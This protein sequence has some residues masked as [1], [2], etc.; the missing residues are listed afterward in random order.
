[1]N[2]YRDHKE[3]KWPQLD[4]MKSHIEQIAVPSEIEERIRSGIRIGRQRRRSRWMAKMASYTAVLLFLVSVASVRFSPVVAAYVGDIPGLRSLVELINY[5]K[6]LQLA[7]ENDFMQQVGRFEEHDG[8]K[9]TIDGILADE[10]RVV[11]FYTLKNMNGQRGI[12]NLQDVKLI[13][14]QNTS[15]LYGASDFKEDWIS[16]QGTIDLNFKEGTAV[17]DVLSLQMKVG[18]D[19]DTASKR[20]AWSFDIPVDKTKFE[21]RRETYALNKTVTVEGQRITFGQMTVYPTRIGIEVVYDPNNTKKLFY[22]DNLRIED[23]HGETFGTISNGISGSIVSENRQLLYIQ[24]NYF[25][26]PSKLYLRASS[27]RALDKAKLEVKVDLANKKLLA[28]PDD[29]L[30][31][32]DIGTSAENGQRILVFGL[33]R[34]DPMDN[35]NR[36]FSIFDSTYADASGHRFESNR[37]GST[38]DEYQYFIKNTSYT[39]PLTLSITDYPSRIY[40]DINVRVK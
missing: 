20:K 10:S 24:S 26:K 14:K 40:G 5:D 9:L 13:N 34:E 33:K 16:K 12:V 7:L 8:I 35:K 4:A 29:R 30:T 21:G 11:V 3:Q 36:Q 22:F 6:G 31:L 27:I 2:E 17:P 15:I 37:T 32:Q 38:G 28:R 18:K 39:N 23:E 1:M 25:R 19:H